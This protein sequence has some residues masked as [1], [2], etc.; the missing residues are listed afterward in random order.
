MEVVSRRK[1]MILG[2]A[3]VGLLPLAAGAAQTAG[4]VAGLPAGTKVYEHTLLKAKPGLRAEL[5]KYV[6]SNWFAMDQKGVEQRIFTSY[7]L[8]EESGE[9]AAWDYV[10]VVGYPTELGYD[11]PQTK[12]VFEAIRKAHVEV[13]IGGKGLR[14]LG[15]VVGSHRLRVVQG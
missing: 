8:L 1:S 5:G 7:W 10:V 3:G 4:L 12:A 2:I 13:K 14:E 11:D 6:V 9:N 15:G